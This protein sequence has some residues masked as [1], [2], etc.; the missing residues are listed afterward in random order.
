MDKKE[1]KLGRSLFIECKVD[2]VHKYYDFVKVY[3]IL[4]R[5][6]AEEALAKSMKP[7]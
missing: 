5:N 3:L 4:F 7:Y 1:V 2:D 6:L